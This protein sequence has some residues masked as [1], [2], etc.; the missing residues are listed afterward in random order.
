MPVNYLNAFE[1]AQHQFDAIAAKTNIDSEVREVLRYPEREFR[2]QIPVRMDNGKI[3]VFFGFRVQHND[4]RGPAKGGIRFA[5][6]ETLDTV[7]ALA[8]WMTWKTAVADIPLGG[9]KGGVVV[10]P[11]TLSVGEKERLCR[12]WIDQ[13]WHDIG[14]RVD[15]PAPDVGTTPQMMAWMMDEYSKLAGHYSPSAITG[16]PLGVGGSLGRTEATGYG[17]VDCIREAMRHLRLKPENSTAAIQGFGNVAQYA[18]IAFK[19]N[20]G[21]KVICVSCYDGNDKESH[22]FSRKEGIDAEFLQSITDQY[23]AIDK[24]EAKEAGYAIEDGNAWLAKK[25]DVLIPAALEGQITG[26]NAH[27]IDPQVRII[28]EGANGPT[29]P[30]ADAVLMQ[31][32]IFNIPDFLCNSGGVICSYFE[33]VQ[34]DMNYYWDH[35]AVLRRLDQK[36]TKAFHGVLETATKKDMHMRDAAY[37]IAIGRVVEAMELRGWI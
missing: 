9:G 35:D 3:R 5:A 18:A 12:G 10:D 34:N 4:A 1:M 11:S 31:R 29:T 13:V 19:K 8:M 37:T 15:V 28:A 32:G 16:K 17:V 33:G 6:N 21:G 27:N 24:T 25:V 14:P 30:E 2:F 22:T 7:R 26:D 23:G 36:I 20:L